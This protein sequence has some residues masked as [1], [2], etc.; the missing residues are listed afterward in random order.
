[1]GELG[2]KRQHD[3]QTDTQ[4]EVRGRGQGGRRPDPQRLKGRQ[5]MEKEGKI[6]PAL[7]L[8]LVNLLRAP[9]SPA[10]RK[11]V[12]SAGGRRGSKLSPCFPWATFPFPGD[13]AELPAEAVPSA[14]R[15]SA[16][17]TAT[18]VLGPEH[19]ISA[20]Q[21][22]E[23]LPSSHATTVCSVPT[24]GPTAGLQQ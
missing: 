2:T 7:F 13:N 1:M 4:C 22:A 8:P 9:A 17:T 24:V 6:Q 18:A 14:H 5:R 23:C 20:R 21:P 19:L 10:V 16:R 3:R 12:L 15:P 11:Q